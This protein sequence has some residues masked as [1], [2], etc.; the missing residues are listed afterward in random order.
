MPLAIG[1]TLEVEIG[2]SVGTVVGVGVIVGG[3]VGGG[4]SVLVAAKVPVMGLLLGFVKVPE[5]LPEIEVLP[6][7]MVPVNL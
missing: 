2:V 4:P 7:E 6:S 5:T 3:V 1:V